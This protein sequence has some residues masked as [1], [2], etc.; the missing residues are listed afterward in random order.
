M[1]AL[2]RKS[3]R[4]RLDGLRQDLRHC[5][6][7][8]ACGDK[9]FAAKSKPKGAGCHKAKGQKRHRCL[10]AKLVISRPPCGGSQ[11]PVLH[12]MFA[13][14]QKMVRDCIFA[15]HPGRAIFDRRLQLE[16]KCPKRA[17]EPSTRQ[18]PGK[19][20]S[21]NLNCE[22]GGDCDKHSHGLFSFSFFA[23]RQRVDG[24]PHHGVAGQC[25]II[26]F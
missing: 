20:R 21:I 25:K 15:I 18:S 3:S 22:Q 24:K 19:G 8:Y 4:R 5:G 23:G 26:L 2:P 16:R 1:I 7:W 12:K 6:F 14:N 17:L 13:D 10:Q 11:A 9:K